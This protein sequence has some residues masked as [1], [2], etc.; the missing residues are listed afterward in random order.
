MGNQVG[1]DMMRASAAFP[2]LVLLTGCNQY[3]AHWA[4]Q[5]TLFE[6]ATSRFS[7]FQA[8][9]RPGAKGLLARLRA[10]P[11]ACGEVRARQ[12]NGFYTDWKKYLVDRRTGA[13]AFQSDLM[14]DRR[15]YEPKGDWQ[16]EKQF[17]ADW[18]AVCVQG[19]QTYAQI[20]AEFDWIK[21]ERLQ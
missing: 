7:V 2:I 18:R 17:L 3:A 20:K 5:G 21:P 16:R 6:P 8:P 10:P 19:S 12:H 4:L 14:L 13:A 11:I 1:P 15:R 9:P